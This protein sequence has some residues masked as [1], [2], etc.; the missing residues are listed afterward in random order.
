MSSRSISRKDFITLTFTL[1]GSAATVRCSSNGNS[2][3]AATNGAGQGGTSGAAAGTTGSGGVSGAGGTS[4]AAGS[5]TTACTD[6]LPE[7]QDPDASGHT[8]TVTVPASTLDAT[9]DQTFTTSSAGLPAHMH[10]VTL[11]PTNLAAIKAGGTADVMSTLV[12]S[13][14][15]SYTVGCH[16]A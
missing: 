6:P 4:G 8:H 14:T 10:M 1:I 5:G 7:M 15:H 16:A 9:T 3:D 12:L 11:T 13:H 2:G